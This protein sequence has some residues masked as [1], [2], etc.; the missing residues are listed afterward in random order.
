[1][2]QT[3]PEQLCTD[4]RTLYMGTPLDERI[5]KSIYNS[6][7]TTDPRYLIFGLAG[8]D[9]IDGANNDDQ[10]IGG[11]GQERI[12]AKQGNDAVWGLE[13]ADTI[14]TR[15]GDDY[16]DGGA[17]NDR[18]YT[19]QGNDTLVGGLGDNSLSGGSGIDLFISQ[20]TRGSGDRDVI[21]NMDE[22]G[23][24]L[25]VEGIDDLNYEINFNQNLV[26]VDRFGQDVAKIMNLA[27]TQRSNTP[28]W[29]SRIRLQGNTVEVIERVDRYGIFVETAEGIPTPVSATRPVPTAC[30]VA[31]TPVEP[32]A[33]S[34][35]NTPE[36]TPSQV[37]QQPEPANTP[38]SVDPAPSVAT[39]PVEH[40]T[41]PPQDIPPSNPG[42]ALAPS[43]SSNPS[44]GQPPINISINIDNSDDNSNTNTVVNDFSSEIFEIQQINLNLGDIISSESSKRERITGTKS[45]DVIGSG[46]GLN[47]LKGMQGSDH[48][49][50]NEADKFKKKTA[51]Q[52]IDFKPNQGDQLVISDEA[53]PGL[54][55]PTFATASSRRDLKALAKEVVDLIYFHKK[56]QLFY[57]ANDETKGMGDGGLFAVLKNK[58]EL[59][60]E[61][62]AVLAG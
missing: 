47:K 32:I 54:D 61:D 11:L 14:F 25:I 39:T 21:Y 50:F 22:V 37:P 60:S 24:K 18:I 46:P 43:P 28:E 59:S 13:D 33:Q 35:T 58:P 9:T 10:I 12:D 56:G 48:F 7:G 49:V 3:S 1:M 29:G 53:L 6:D 57:N 31:P 30:D 8:N 20:Y 19:H 51:D 34:A 23:E 45:D 5:K 26:L 16:A 40:E 62:L 17:G 2:P 15:E 42:N 38:N 36:S 4:G 41:A 52:I 55:D 27:Q 44:I